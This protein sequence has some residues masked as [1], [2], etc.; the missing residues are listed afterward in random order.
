MRTFD[1]DTGESLYVNDLR[2]VRWEQ[3]G[4]GANLPFQAMWYSIPPGDQSPVDQHP[5]LEL[6]IVVAGTAHVLIGDSVQEIR[7][8]NAFLLD[9]KEAHVV[10]NRS[11]DEVLTVF[12]AYWYPEAAEAAAAALAAAERQVATAAAGHD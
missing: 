10:Q 4:L 5:E 2:V 6:S 7:H 8:G 9:S 1:L 12:S 3:Y 11:E